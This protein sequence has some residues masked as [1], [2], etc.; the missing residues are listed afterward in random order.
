MNNLTGMMIFAQVVQS[1]SFSKAAD[2]L[3]MSKSSVSKKITFLE[4]R[5]GVRLLNRTTRKLS[6][7]EVG[8][9]FYER[10]ERIM[11]EAEEAELAITRL[12]DEPRGHLKISAPVSFGIKHLGKPLATFMSQYEDLSVE[13][14][15]NDRF[16]DIVEE[17]FDMAIRIG[18]LP[19][20]SLIAKKIGVSRLL[21]VAAPSYLEKHGRPQHPHDL[22]DHKCMS[23]TLSRGAGHWPFVE[24]GKPM[25]VK[26][27][28]G[29][30]VNNGDLARDMTIAG[31][32]IAYSP[33][34]IIG[35]DVRE[36]RVEV[37][38]GEF[39]PEP[40]NM[41]AVYPHN[42]HLSAKVRLFV[43]FLKD[44]FSQCPSWDTKL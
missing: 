7:T 25:S 41:Y 38:L 16:V 39:E 36:G 35:P 37:L 24:D 15:L 28:G 13:V 18:R 11:S 5:L 27:D 19:D 29:I 21:V 43:G 2:T 4:D 32:G 44:W 31:A 14:S 1:G 17:G 33:S 22:E 42:R 23:Y 3:G 8:Q 9:V 40:V 30:K 12:Q 6:L 34:F 26:I 10:C 20:S